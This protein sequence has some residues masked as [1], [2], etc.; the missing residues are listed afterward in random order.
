MSKL[1]AFESVEVEVKSNYCV[2]HY[3]NH[4]PIGPVKYLF[5]NCYHMVGT[6]TMAQL[7]D[8]WLRVVFFL[9]NIHREQT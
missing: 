5:I 8:Y 3:K 7:C 2:Q 6:R 1:L 9:L 4:E